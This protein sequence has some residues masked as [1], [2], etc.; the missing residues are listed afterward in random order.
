MWGVATA[1]ENLAKTGF[2]PV[3]TH[4]LPQDPCNAYFIARV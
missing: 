2:A 1:E 3:E 4:D